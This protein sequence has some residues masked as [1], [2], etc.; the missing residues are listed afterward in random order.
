MRE[1]SGLLLLVMV[2]SCSR[3]RCHWGNMLVCVL[4]LNRRLLLVGGVA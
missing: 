1:V 2:L 4:N 3:F